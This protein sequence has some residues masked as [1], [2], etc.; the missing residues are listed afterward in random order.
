MK[1]T[2]ISGVHYVARHFRGSQRA[3]GPDGKPNG[4]SEAAFRPKNGEA[5]GISVYWVDFFQG[6]PNKLN[7]IR[8]VVSLKVT[9]THRLAVFR[10][11]IASAAITA[12]GFAPVIIED[13]CNDLPPDTNAAHALVGPIDALQQRAVREAIASSVR[14][15]DVVTFNLDP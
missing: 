3:Y 13:P 6:H 9:S 8:S 1:G 5:I 12:V 14:E 7:C 15:S 11:G 4:V 10:A 2:P